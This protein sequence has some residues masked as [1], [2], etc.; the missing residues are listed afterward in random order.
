MLLQQL[1]T[2]TTVIGTQ[3]ML[4]RGHIILEEIAINTKV[5]QLVLIIVMLAVVAEARN[6][7]VVSII[8]VG[9]KDII[10][11][12]MEEPAVGITNKIDLFK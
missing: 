11:M 7:P 2:T 1:M 10:P 5:Q 12:L 9:K 8:P 4:N 6:T 3:I